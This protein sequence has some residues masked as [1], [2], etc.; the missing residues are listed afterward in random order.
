MRT[1]RTGRLDGRYGSVCSGFFF[2]LLLRA[3]SFLVSYLP[4]TS[5]SYYFFLHCATLSRGTYYLE[6]PKGTI[7]ADQN[8]VELLSY[9][10]GRSKFP[11]KKRIRPYAHSLLPEHPVSLY[12]RVKI[13]KRGRATEPLMTIPKVKQRRKRKKIKRGPLQSYFLAKWQ[14]KKKRY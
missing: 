2:L 11:L 10:R 3:S 4:L 13:S 7:F 6:Y 9:S 12:R 14:K 8:E 5:G 1:G